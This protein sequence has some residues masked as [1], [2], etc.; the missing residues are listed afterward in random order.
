MQLNEEQILA[1]APDEASRKAGRDLANSVKWSN[2]GINDKALWGECQGSGKNPYKTQVDLL[3]VAFKCSCPSRK[4]PCKHGLGILLLYGRQNNLFSVTNAPDWVNEWI[5]KRNEKVEK[6]SEKV[7]KPVDIETQAKRAQQRHKKIELGIQELQLFLKDIV[8]NGILN[9][10]EKA[11]AIFNNLA[12]RMIDA[13]APGLAFMVREL[14]EINY[15]KENWHTQFIDQIAKLHT[16]ST[17]YQN[18]EQLNE[19]LKEDI[20]TIVGYNRNNDNLMLQN[21]IIDHWFVLAKTIHQ[22]EQLQIQKT[23]LHGI[24]TGKNA[25][26][27]QYFVKSQQPE[28]NLT[29]GTI[30]DAEIVYFTSAQPHQAIIKSLQGVQTMLNINFGFTDWD[31]M[32]NFERNLIQNFPFIT[33]QVFLIRQVV[34]ATKNQFWYL[35]DKA[36]VAIPLIANEGVRLKMLA[37]TG[38]ELFNLVI[39]GLEGNYTPVA[40]II[41]D[42]YT[43]LP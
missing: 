20:R 25:L 36:G 10:P 30:A 1:L 5:E 14:G 42:N 27:I 8:R 40:I 28:L 23:W 7:S 34:L 2:Q 3:N 21:G 35:K 43:V 9:I 12:K 16:A 31:Q 17:A 29:P 32:F 19:L 6:A 4:F 13:Q 41:N 26:I 15:F 22:Q 39:T 18:I 38:G 11:P 33:S 24:K 37:I